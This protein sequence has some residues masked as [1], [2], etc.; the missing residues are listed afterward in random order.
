MEIRAG[1]TKVTYYIT[2]RQARDLAKERM[3]QIGAPGFELARAEGS[4]FGDGIAKRS[5]RKGIGGKIRGA[6]LVA[7]EFLT[8]ETAEKI[9]YV[10]SLKNAEGG[11]WTSAEFEKITGISREALRQ[12][13][14]AFTIVYWTDARGHCSYPKW[15]FDANMQVLPEVREILGL[16]KTHDTLS[17]LM[18]FLVPAVGDAGNSPLHLIQAGRGCEAVDFGRSIV[19]EH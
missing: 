19:C 8:K 4:S 9:A 15:Q 13:R 3:L 5:P 14:N 12:R 2:R 11:A 1:N 18:T 10:R 17:V 7:R 16:L 6:T